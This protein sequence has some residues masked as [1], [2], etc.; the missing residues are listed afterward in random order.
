MFINRTNSAEA[1][2][3]RQGRPYRPIP[4]PC[5]SAV[6]ATRAVQVLMEHDMPTQAETLKAMERRYSGDPD[7]VLSLARGLAIVEAFRDHGEGLTVAQAAA[8]TGL[9]RAAVR[10]M[11]KT[12]L[13]TGH[14]T[15]DGRL[16]TLTPR[17]LALTAGYLTS[18][19]LPDRLQ[20]I[21]EHVN[22][23]LHESCSAS[24]LEGTEIVY[25]ARAAGRRIMSV[26]LSVGSRLPAHC[27]SM[28][29][30]LIAGLRGV[31]RQVLIP[32]LDLKALTP[33]T[34]VERD[35]L[36]REIDRVAADGYCIVDQELELG[37][38][39]I[40]HPV[41]IPGGRTVAAINVSVQAARMSVEDL[42]RDVLP[43]LREAAQRIAPTL[44]G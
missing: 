20:P 15:S 13:A 5:G 22:E 1:D 42:R 41:A 38:R 24:V 2:P 9:D 39:S 8:R 28:G 25:V 17:V 37:L 27:T 35:R 11:L 44:G 3:L 32:R 29:R 12:L 4:N 30:V 16:Y 34:I 43:V 18:G 7:F 31:E 6:R 19:S 26:S 36:V 14:A 33:Y 21:L 40:A 10:R 23:R